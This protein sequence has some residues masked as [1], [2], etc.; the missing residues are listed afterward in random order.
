MGYINIQKEHTLKIIV[1]KHAVDRYIERKGGMT[2][3][4]SFSMIMNAVQPQRHQIKDGLK[5]LKDI[6][7]QI[8]DKF[9]GIVVKD[10]DIYMV[11]TVREIKRKG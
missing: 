3:N 8:D 1:S 9:V 6:R 2:I 11:V 10:G 7:V 5:I 4:Q